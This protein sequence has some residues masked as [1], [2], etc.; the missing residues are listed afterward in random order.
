MRLTRQRASLLVRAL[1][2]GVVV[3]TGGLAVD[4]AVNVLTGGS[5]PGPL[6]RYRWLA[7]PTVLVAFTTAVTAA[8]RE[9]LGHARVEARAA[10]GDRPEGQLPDLPPVTRDFT[11][12]TRELEALRAL[13]P[14]AEASARAAP[15]VVTV[16]GPMGVGKSM[17]AIRFAHDVSRSYPDGQFYLNLV[18][19]GG[20]PLDTAEALRRLLRGMGAL[21]DLPLDLDGL[22]DLYRSRLRGRRA[23]V[24][25]DHA[26]SEAQVQPLLADQPGCLTLITSQQPLDGLPHASPPVRLNVMSDDEAVALLSRIAGDHLMSLEHAPD[27]KEVV[28]LCGHLPLAL[29]IAGVLLRRNPRRSVRDLA[30]QLADVRSRLEV[31]HVGNLDV[32]ASFDVS[33]AHLSQMEQ[34]LFRRLSVVPQPSFGAELAAALL[35]CPPPEAERLLD[36]LVDEQMLEMAGD[37]LYAFQNLIGLYAREKLEREEPSAEQRSAQGRA[38]RASIGT[39]MQQAMLLDNAALEVL[40]VA[41]D[42]PAPAS[43]TLEAQLA[44]LDWLERER[45]NLVLVA[46]QAALLPGDDVAWRLAAG[47]GLF[48]DLRGYWEDWKAVQEAA[49][50]SAHPNGSLKAQAWSALGTGQILGL[51]RSY[52]EALAHL[53]EALETALA[54]RWPRVA[55]RAQYL[56]G[57]VEH[58]RGRY[59]VAIERYGRAA[60]TFQDE[61]ML[62]ELSSTLFYVAVALFDDGELPAEEVVRVGESVLATLAD[63]PEQLW[64]LRTTGRINECF[65]HI[66]E[67]L[68]D[69]EGAGTYYL[70]SGEAFS[71]AF[72][73][74]GHGRVR[75]NLGRIR[76]Q[77]G[78]F[79]RAHEILAHSL[80][81]FNTIGDRYQEAQSLVLLGEA[82]HSLGRVPE[83]R[84]SWQ[85]A[86]T[87]YAEVGAAAETEAAAARARL[88]SA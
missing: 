24:V 40:E 53:E 47:L 8:V 72:F 45:A 3:A 27:M 23:V 17:L 34:A 77:Q 13:L 69:L 37:R 88:E 65:G 14:P 30:S 25:L 80:T 86:L 46:R 67:R 29:S 59:E 62:A 31:L 16:H 71:R 73:R 68:G 83:A 70:R 52:D 60:R 61:G 84:A 38:L 15:V 87:T 56:M 32:R 48:F 78:H 4:F 66:A 79:D 18:T 54:G 50:I 35:G 43:V 57:R 19:L 74:H 44:A 64:T 82:Q 9:R 63:E 26:Q 1:L 49:W 22:A 28:T 58:E 55:A 33:Y 11:G 36:R 42:P 7:L 12:R 39:A 41:A 5:L 51:D 81:L 85:A 2:Y 76:M 20:A 75:R 21:L 10:A 6:D